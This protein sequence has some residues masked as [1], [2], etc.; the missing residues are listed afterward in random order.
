MDRRAGVEMREDCMGQ[1]LTE[2][3]LILMLVALVAISGLTLLGGTLSSL[4]DTITSS[5]P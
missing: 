2:Y 4:F 3:A 1:G 5:W